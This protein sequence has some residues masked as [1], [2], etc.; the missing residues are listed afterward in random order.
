MSQKQGT[1]LILNEHDDHD[2]D[3]DDDENVPKAIEL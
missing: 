2:D 3:H 1:H